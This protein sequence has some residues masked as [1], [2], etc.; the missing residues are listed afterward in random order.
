MTGRLKG[1]HVE[2]PFK[3]TPDDSDGINVN[4]IPHNR[5]V[6]DVQAVTNG[7]TDYIVLPPLSKVPDGHTISIYCNAGGAFEIRTP[8]ASGEEINSEDC[9]GTK[10]YL[11]T[12]TQIITVR[13]IDGTV[14]WEAHGHSAIGAAVTAVIPD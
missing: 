3:V 10:E 4:L 14:G 8:S 2:R 5:T 11:A 13:K 6:I 1:G 7:V 9:D 12:D